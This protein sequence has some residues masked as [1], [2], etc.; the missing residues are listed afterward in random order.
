MNYKKKYLELLATHS[1]IMGLYER[2][3]GEL[4]TANQKNNELE[5]RLAVIS[6][7]LELMR[8]PLKLLERPP[9]KE[10]IYSIFIPPEQEAV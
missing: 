3:I 6:R 9:T 7:E 2:S 8:K 4:S 1:K 5:L 10:R